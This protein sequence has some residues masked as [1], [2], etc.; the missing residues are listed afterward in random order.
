MLLHWM[1]HYIGCGSEVICT[2]WYARLSDGFLEIVTCGLTNRIPHIYR[3]RLVLSHLT[4][5][6]VKLSFVAFT[7]IEWDAGVTMVMIAFSAVLGLGSV[8][9]ACL[10][11]QVM[12]PSAEI[13]LEI[14]QI[15]RDQ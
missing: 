10:S 4:R 12:R 14:N 9:T 11:R 1:W 8:Q 2:E 3:S 7:A 15:S 6:Q 5:L 13:T